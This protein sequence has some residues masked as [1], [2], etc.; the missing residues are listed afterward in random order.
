[1]DAGPS[2]LASAALSAF[3]QGCLAPCYPQYQRADCTI[4]VFVTSG[5][6]PTVP[7]W[8]LSQA[9]L[10]LAAGG[11]LKTGDSQA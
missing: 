4:P 8:R 11:G 7:C 6:E 1:M 3:A 2:R 9:E 5:G 10:W